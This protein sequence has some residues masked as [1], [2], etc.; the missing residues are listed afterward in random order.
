MSDNASVTDNNM[1]SGTNGT[2]VSSPTEMGPV[3]GTSTQVGHN[4]NGTAIMSG[5]GAG[6]VNTN[7]IM[8]QDPAD[9]TTRPSKRHS[10]GSDSRPPKRYRLDLISRT[11]NDENK[12]SARPQAVP[13]TARP[14]KRLRDELDSD[15]TPDAHDSRPPKRY[16]LDMINR[17]S[18]AESQTGPS[19]TRPLKRLHDELDNDDS[20]PP[21]RY[22]LDL[23]N[24][25][26][27]K[28]SGS[29]VEPPTG[30]SPSTARPLKRPHDELDT[31]ATPD[32]DARPPKRYR[33]DLI[34][35]RRGTFDFFTFPGEVRNRIYGY[36]TAAVA[37][38]TTTTPIPFRK[39]THTADHT[40]TTRLQAI[41][42]A[43]SGLGRSNR[44]LR[45]EFWPLL[46]SSLSY[47][48]CDCHNDTGTRASRRQRHAVGLGE[49]MPVFPPMLTGP[50]ELGCGRVSEL[51]FGEYDRHS[52]ARMHGVY[53]RP[54]LVVA[55]LV[56]VLAKL[57]VVGTVRTSGVGNVVEM[58]METVRKVEECMRD[59]RTGSLE[60]AVK[61]VCEKQVWRP[62]G[63]YAWHW[64][65]DGEL[66]VDFG[67][68][69]E[70]ER[71]KGLVVPLYQAALRGVERVW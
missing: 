30:P 69:G 31:E 64:V 23:I 65:V 39:C 25:T 53:S 52:R 13:S 4:M 68:F 15:T 9:S 1:C 14:T 20:R 59:V 33:L 22:R 54:V 61:C 18:S 55:Q 27:K 28:G 16:R 38:E 6:Q 41:H 5:G 66:K 44:R 45:L 67:G 47:R 21:K 19:A 37:A 36:L 58:W 35:K 70:D 12:T 10:P 60:E 26:Q 49:V 32:A 62:Q 43:F 57:E 34:N 2:K 8:I 17:N 51:I 3:V 24:R 71:F 48:L 50:V 29:S 42:H 11:Q 46:W 7:G 63:G 56:A 40:G